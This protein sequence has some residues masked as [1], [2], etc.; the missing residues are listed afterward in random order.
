M[1]KRRFI[2]ISIT[3]I[4]V[5]ALSAGYAFADANAMVSGGLS[6]LRRTFNQGRIAALQPYSHLQNFNGR[7]IENVQDK[8]ID[9][10]HARSVIAE[11]VA[12]IG[13][14]NNA[15]IIIA[16]ANGD[17]IASHD[18]KQAFE[19]ASTLKTLTAL[20]AS[21]TFDSQETLDTT[22]KLE[23]TSRT[24]TLVGGGDILLGR[25]NSDAHHVNG[26]AGLS[27]LADQTAQALK[28]RNISEVNFQYDNSLFN[29][30]TLPR[31]LDASSDVNE[32]YTNEI[33]TTS[34]AID[35]ARAWGS[36]DG[37]DPDGEGQWS[38]QR[39][40]RPAHDVAQTFVSLLEERGI[41]VENSTIAQSAAS[42]DS[43]EIATVKS[44][45]MWQIV[46]IM[47]TNSDNSLAQLLGRLLAI[48]TGQDNSL[49][50][51]TQAVIDIVKRQG[52]DT[53]GL[54]MSDTSGLA[55]G[56]AVTARTLIHVQSAYLNTRDSNN[57]T[58]A[59][60][61]GMPISQL[62]G[63]LRARDFGA[64]ARGLVRA[65]TGTL[66]NV[67]SLA[68]NVSRTNGG[69]LIFA[70]VVNGDDMATGKSAIDYFASRLVDL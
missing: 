68:G 39:S 36:D 27:T 6:V 16:Q 17:I 34:M 29:N 64:Q 41:T 67:T 37:H 42:A 23:A 57:S 40:A 9:K 51:S 1:H 59:A 65:K 13:N 7:T 60:A 26:R 15:G 19:P 70:I 33:E 55:P 12:R 44:A 20:A 46:Q 62:S 66:G 69:T 4:V 52:I 10:E 8:K 5:V 38:P 54:V 30:D 47:L 43:F 11:T 31:Q 45:P 22:V 61:T 2:T 32:N 53:Q 28:K 50:G 18:E 24:L 58:W 25:G 49:N 3:A 14:G 56:S 48:R 63:T 35:E 21:V